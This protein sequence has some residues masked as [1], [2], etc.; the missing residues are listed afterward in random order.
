M[1]DYNGSTKGRTSVADDVSDLGA[2]WSQGMDEFTIKTGV[3]L[4][5]PHYNVMNE[6]MTGANK[7][8]DD[9]SKFRHNEGKLHRVR[10]AFGRHLTDIQKAT[11]VIQTAASAASVRHKQTLPSTSTGPNLTFAYSKLFLLQCQVLHQ[12]RPLHSSCRYACLRNQ[13]DLLRE[14][15]C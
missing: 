13:I 4:K 8:L 10:S 6:A 11:V 12:S 15:F 2:L 9:F 3:N 14:V 1:A 7:Q 5:L